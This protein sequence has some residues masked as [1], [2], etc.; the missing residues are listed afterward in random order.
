MRVGNKRWLC[1]GFLIRHDVGSIPTRPTQETSDVS[2]DAHGVSK[3][4][5]SRE[6]AKQVK[7]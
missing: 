5:V 2:L 6:T 7:C 1:S 4:K 3:T